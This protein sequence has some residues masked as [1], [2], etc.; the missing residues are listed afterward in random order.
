MFLAQT[1]G[2]QPAH[3]MP[4]QSAQAQTSFAPGTRSFCGSCGSP[5]ALGVRFCSA[6]ANKS[7]GFVQ[8]TKIRMVVSP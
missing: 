6:A 5:V 1:F 4:N 3:Q 2:G 8:A 7:R